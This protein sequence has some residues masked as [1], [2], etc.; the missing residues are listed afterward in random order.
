MTEGFAQPA[1]RKEV[2]QHIHTEAVN[3]VTFLGIREGGQGLGGS[4]DLKPVFASSTRS[5]VQLQSMF[6]A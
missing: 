6:A 5:V 2:H 1:Q 4:R 3:R